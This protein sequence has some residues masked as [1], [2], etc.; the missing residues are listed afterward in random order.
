M[1]WRIAAPTGKVSSCVSTWHSG[2]DAWRSSIL[3]E[4]A[5]LCP[6]KM[7]KFGSPTTANCT[8]FSNCE[9]CWRK[10]VMSFGPMDELGLVLRREV[11]G[12]DLHRRQ[13]E[14]AA[15]QRFEHS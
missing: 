1:L 3:M 2:I 13:A 5:S 11:W 10:R 15:S 14:L 4:A 6:M 8:I 9:I 12:E 7:E